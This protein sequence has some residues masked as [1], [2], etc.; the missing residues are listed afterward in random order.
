M[1]ILNLPDLPKPA[2]HYSHCI[3]HNG[4]LYISGQLPIWDNP[5][6]LPEEISEQTK[7]VL[8]K[9]SKILVAAGSS[10]Q[11]VLQVRI[12]I[13]DIEFWNVVNQVYS[14]FFGDHRP[15]RTIV[16]VQ[17]LHYDCKIEIDAIAHK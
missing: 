2:G 14:D 8:D 13:T 9:L 15:A 11:K 16:P 17:Q 7:I 12:Y 1:E 10:I 6:S 3:E 4:I 5:K